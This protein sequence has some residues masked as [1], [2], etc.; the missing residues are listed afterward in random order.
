MKTE[1]KSVSWINLPKQLSFSADSILALRG[2]LSKS[3]Y[4][5]P[6]PSCWDIPFLKKKER[7]KE[8]KERK[9]GGL[10]C[11]L[12]GHGENTHPCFI[13]SSNNIVLISFTAWS[14]ALGWSLSPLAGT[15][16]CSWSLA[17]NWK[18]SHAGCTACLKAPVADQK[19]WLMKLGCTDLLGKQITHLFA[20]P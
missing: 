13:S 14:L 19:K 17:A 11:S 10:D 1:R 8:K 7:S 18:Q 5:Q 9:L 2:E 3:L 16:H 6:C 20:L 12:S 4:R 15:L